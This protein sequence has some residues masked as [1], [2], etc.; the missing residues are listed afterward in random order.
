LKLMRGGNV[1]PFS[2]LM[3]TSICMNGILVWI[4]QVYS[5]YSSSEGGS[6]PI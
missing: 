1:G 4:L 3:A 5:S 2:I 6:I